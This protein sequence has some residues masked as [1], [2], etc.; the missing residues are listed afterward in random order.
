MVGH[1][2][3]VTEMWLISVSFELGLYDIDM[4]RRNSSIYLLFLKRCIMLACDWGV[5]HSAIWETFV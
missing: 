4:P 2:I 1:L 3:L 5:R